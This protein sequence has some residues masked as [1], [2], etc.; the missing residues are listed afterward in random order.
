M[1][2]LIGVILGAIIA[3]IILAIFGNPLTML[4]DKW[5]NYRYKKRTKELYEEYL[6]KGFD[7]NTARYISGYREEF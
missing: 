7:D 1:S 5:E 6:A 3:N 4:L 2:A